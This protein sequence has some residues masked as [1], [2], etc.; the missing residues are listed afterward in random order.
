MLLTHSKGRVG[1][2]SKLLGKSH[3]ELVQV[4]D[5]SPRP[6]FE[7]RFWGDLGY[8]HLCFDINGMDDMRK[9]CES[10]GYPFTCDSSDSFDM[11][12]AAGHFSYIED[13]DG[14]LI[15]FVETH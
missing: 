2:F 13:P 4:I 7:N 12:E 8:I 15:E 11:G 9:L 10:K 5:R 14:T 6:I 1:A 3:I